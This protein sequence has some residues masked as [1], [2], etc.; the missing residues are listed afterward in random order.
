MIRVIYIYGT[1]KD[2]LTESS[3]ITEKNT[4]FQN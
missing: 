4:K 3:K 1:Q 2:V